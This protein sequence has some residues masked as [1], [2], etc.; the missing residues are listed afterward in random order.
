MFQETLDVRPHVLILNKMDLAD[1]SSKQVKDLAA[2]KAILHVSST[3]KLLRL[4]DVFT[5]YP[6]E[7][8]EE[9]GKRWGE[10]RSLHRLF[11]ATT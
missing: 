7:N 5:F 8:P 11:N 9:A 3:L 6:L 10:E 2:I 4:N 1:L